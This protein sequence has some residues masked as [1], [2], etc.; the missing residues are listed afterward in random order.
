MRRPHPARRSAT[1]PPYRVRIVPTPAVIDA[2]DTIL[3]DAQV[4]EIR[5]PGDRVETPG[6]DTPVVAGAGAARIRIG[7]ITIRG[8]PL[9]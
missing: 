9:C 8:V 4:L 6:G 5:F 1:P 3:T 7:A 2:Q